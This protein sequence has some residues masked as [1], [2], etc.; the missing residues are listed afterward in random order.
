LWTTLGSDHEGHAKI[1]VANTLDRVL[2][3]ASIGA[4]RAEGRGFEAPGLIAALR[5]RSG[6]ASRKP[7]WFLMDSSIVFWHQM[8]CRRP[9]RTIAPTQLDRRAT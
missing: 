9:R 5:L 6:A 2:C 3:Q 4:E 7:G 1:N 8:G